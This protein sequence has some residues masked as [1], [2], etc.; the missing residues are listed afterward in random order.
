MLRQPSV[1]EKKH[2]SIKFQRESQNAS[3]DKGLRRE[4]SRSPVPTFR[5]DPLVSLLH[6][7]PTNFISHD[8]KSLRGTV[9]QMVMIKIWQV[10]PRISTIGTEAASRLDF[11]FRGRLSTESICCGRRSCGRAEGK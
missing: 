1:K 10:L 2:F 3:E 5:P 9:K 8:N 7:L 11:K 4:A 6:A